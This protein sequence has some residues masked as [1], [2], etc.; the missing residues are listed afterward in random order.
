MQVLTSSS[1]SISS[2]FTADDWEY[3]QSS[4]RYFRNLFNIT[5]STVYRRILAPCVIVTAFS[6]LVATHNS[7][8]CQRGC[9][10]Q[11]TNLIK[12]YLSLSWVYP[13]LSDNSVASHA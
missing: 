11:L 8:V 12:K 5:E 4:A 6:A 13:A 2:F 7:L 1:H 3:H 10:S 9:T